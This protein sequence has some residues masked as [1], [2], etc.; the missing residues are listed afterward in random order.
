MWTLMI[1]TLMGGLNE[2]E[3]YETQLQCQQVAQALVYLPIVDPLGGVLCLPPT[4]N[5]E[6]DGDEERHPA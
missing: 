1:L 5:V 3:T 4:P 6:D 2:V